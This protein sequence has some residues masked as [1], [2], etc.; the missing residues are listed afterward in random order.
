MCCCPARVQIGRALSRKG[1]DGGLVEETGAD[2]F[3]GLLV[4]QGSPVAGQSI[5]SAGAAA[6]C[7][8]LLPPLPAC[9]QQARVD[10]A[11]ASSQHASADPPAC[12]PACH[13]ACPAPLP[14]GLRNLDGQFVVSVRRGGQL[15][16]A[17]GPEFMLAAGDV[18][19]LSGG[20]HSVGGRQV[21]EAA[22]SKQ[23]S[24]SPPPLQHYCG[25][26]AVPTCPFTI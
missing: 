23:Q 21:A 14:A 13:P 1:G 17:V 2:F 26:D 11:P 19:Y 4:A 16:H 10:C 25:C 8:L 22:S 6:H 9:C 15:V 5:E 7:C 20:C 24:A 3:M 18:L 12:L